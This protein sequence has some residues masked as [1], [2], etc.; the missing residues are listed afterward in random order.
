MVFYVL[1]CNTLHYLFFIYY[2][3]KR[4]VCY[5]CVFTALKMTRVVV[6]NKKED[7]KEVENYRSISSLLAFSKNIDRK[8]N[9]YIEKHNIL[10]QKHHGFRKKWKNRNTETALFDSIPKGVCSE[11]QKL[12]FRPCILYYWMS[13]FYGFSFT[14]WFFRYFFK[15]IIF[16]LF[17]GY[18]LVVIASLSI[19]FFNF[20]SLF[21]LNFSNLYYR[22]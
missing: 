10:S 19:L 11:S 1:F 9:E 20:W 5:W 7:Q 8:L 3:Y 6:L 14:F 22:I 16:P 2:N 12:F 21:L 4:I 13:F 15:S 17:F 18:R